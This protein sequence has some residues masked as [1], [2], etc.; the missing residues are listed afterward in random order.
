MASESGST[1]VLADTPR[2][3]RQLRGGDLTKKLHNQ[4]LGELKTTHDRVQLY[5]NESDRGYVR[6]C[7]LAFPIPPPSTI[8]LPAE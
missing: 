6:L 2:R 5:D 7:Y 3:W 4:K 1:E 8:S